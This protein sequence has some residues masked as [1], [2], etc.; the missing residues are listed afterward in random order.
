MRGSSKLCSRAATGR[1]RDA[2]WG[3]CPGPAPTEPD[4]PVLEATRTRSEGHG[5]NEAASGQRG[6]HGA[7]LG[8]WRALPL[9]TTVRRPW[10]VASCPGQFPGQGSEAQKGGRRGSPAPCSLPTGLV[11][12]AA[13]GRT[14][15]PWNSPGLICPIRGIWEMGATVLQGLPPPASLWAPDAC[16]HQVPIVTTRSA[17]PAPRIRCNTMRTGACRPPPA[18]PGRAEPTPGTRGSASWYCQA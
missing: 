1:G 13:P 2:S 6:G 12:E 17:Q 3:G 5:Q 9:A 10:P 18:S 7:G 4:L 8:P 15:E 16:L 11:G 14:G